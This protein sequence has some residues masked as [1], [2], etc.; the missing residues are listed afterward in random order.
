MK[1]TQINTI[2]EGGSGIA[3][4]RI[5]EG[6]LKC[7][8]DSHFLT[9]KTLL[10]NRNNSL[11]NRLKYYL[12]ERK[13]IKTNFK[14]LQGKVAGYDI[15]TLPISPHKY[16]ADFVHVIDTDV[17]HFH[18]MSHLLDYNSFF[19]KV[20]R[21][22]VW[23]LH[24]MNPFTGG[25]HY[26]SGCIGFE[27]Y[28]SLCP[29]LSGTIN[30]NHAD[31]MLQLKERSF[32]NISDKQMIV[33]TPSRWLMELSKKSRLFSRF[34]HVT[35][36]NGLNTNVFKVKN[37]K[38]IRAKFGLSDTQFV[39]LFVASS[40]KDKR[41]GFFLLEKTLQK[42]GSDFTLL[43]VG[44]VENKELGIRYFDSIDDENIL[45]DLYNAADIFV[46]PSLEDN[47]PNTMIEALSCGT[48]IVGFNI[49][50]IGEVVRYGMDGYLSDDV[51]ENGL[52]SKINLIRETISTFIRQEISHFA[53][54]RFDQVKQAQKYIDLY[55]KI[56]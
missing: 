54:N 34:E 47:L 43:C 14:Y 49:G 7:G 30:D 6:L 37:R 16:L 17:I 27:K 21:P 36:H 25:C 29:Q 40:V 42:L 52:L 31:E 39:V 50:G 19:Q 33:V 18:W 12:A 48:P 53:H 28:C 41:K 24:D 20:K 55:Q 5:H 26:S 44:K 38:E 56:I 35:I 10:S 11:Y 13:Y 3:C 51:S 8:V 45:S 15:F 32:S 22:I 4:K 23:T 9:L 1:V 46:L 2:S